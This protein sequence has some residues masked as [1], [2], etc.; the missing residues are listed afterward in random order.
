MYFVLLTVEK[1][2][3]IQNKSGK[4]LN[5][6]KWLYTILFVVIGWVI[7]R[8]DTISDALVYLKSMFGLNG[9]V[10]SDVMFTGW[11]AQYIILLVI[12]AVICTPVFRV[13]SEKTKNSTAVGVIK[14]V[15][16]LGLFILSVASLLGDSYNPFI[17]FNF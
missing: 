8:S 1:L 9:N 3:G 4:A 14:G 6:F 11:L 13:L 17:Y 10:F 12:G 2:T 5:V 15:G 16:L 7:F